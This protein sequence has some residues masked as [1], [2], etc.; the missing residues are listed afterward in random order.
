MTINNFPSNR[1]LF[2]TLHE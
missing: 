1:K 2:L